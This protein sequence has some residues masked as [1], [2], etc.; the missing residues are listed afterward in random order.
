MRTRQARRMGVVLAAV[1]MLALGGSVVLA[2]IPSGGGMIY[3]CYS[4]STGA[5]R[6]VNYP[7]V[8]CKSSERLL[9]WTQIGPK[10]PP[11]SSIGIKNFEMNSSN[12]EFTA[13]DGTTVL[14]LWAE[15]GSN[16]QECLASLGEARLGV[17]PSQH[18]L[19]EPDRP[20]RRRDVARRRLPASVPGRAA[21]PGLR[22]LGER[23]P[24]GCEVLRHSTEV[25]HAGLQRLA[26]NVSES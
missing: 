23:L 16:K 14:S 2:A 7:A 21:R 20:V 22:L 9:S 12:V 5:M 25:R 26:R 10:A 3:A 15:T 19:R 4:K 13:Q 11:L 18:L 1:V 24:G 8:R 6:V 17:F